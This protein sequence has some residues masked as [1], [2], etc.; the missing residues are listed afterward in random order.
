MLK[1]ILILIISFIFCLNLNL[2]RAL[3]TNS[4]KNNLINNKTL[5]GVY[6]EYEFND[7]NFQFKTIL[8]SSLTEKTAITLC[9]P[10]LN[11]YIFLTT[12]IF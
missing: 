8:N 1:K 5:Y 10:Q 11:Y 2:T 7:K 4:C 9:V 12:L 3:S 6:F